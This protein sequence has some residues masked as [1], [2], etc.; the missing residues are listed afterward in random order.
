MQGG[1]G[2]EG[3]EGVKRWLFHHVSQ[4]KAEAGVAR[5]SLVIDKTRFACDVKSLEPKIKLK[6]RAP[7]S[8]TVPSTSGGVA[9]PAAEPVSRLLCCAW[10]WGSA[11][12]WDGD[13]D[14]DVVVVVVQCRVPTPFT[15]AGATH[16]GI[17]WRL[18]V[19]QRAAW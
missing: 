17:H 15:R 1:G 5:A 11:A 13:G 9:T 18:S 2:R 7:A 6:K 8:S 19:L 12:S 16:S 10:G 4:A 3:K 14:G